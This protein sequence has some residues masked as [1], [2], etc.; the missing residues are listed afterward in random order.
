MT[1]LL[2]ILLLYRKGILV[3]PWIGMILF[4]CQ[5]SSDLEASLATPL[6]EN[7]DYN[8][9]IKPILSDRCYAC[10]GPD[11]KT[12]EADLRLDT[13]EGALKMKLESGKP[14]IV[15][16]STSRSE[17][18]H[19][20]TSDDPQVLMPPPESHLTLSDYE[21]ALLG[22]WI[23]Q[24]AEWK[25]HWSFIPPERPDIPRISQKDFPIHEI[26]HFIL[27]QLERKGLTPS[28][29]ADKTRLIRRLSL[30]LRGLPP[31]LEEIDV[32]LQDEDPDAYEKLVDTYLSDPA[33]GERMALDWMDVA[34]YADSHGMHADGWRNMWPWRDWVIQAFNDNMPYDQFIMYQMAGDM[35]PDATKDQILATAFHRNHQMTAEGGVIDEE[36]RL[37]YVFDRTNTTATAFLGLTMECARC[38]DHKFDPL[39]QKDFYALAAF[40]N[41]VKEVGMTGDDGNYGPVMLMSSDT[42]EAKLNALDQ[43]INKLYQQKKLSQSEVQAQKAFLTTLDRSSV[44]PQRFLLAHYPLDKLTKQRNASGNPQ[45]LLD[46]NDQST[47]T[48][49]PELVKGKIGKALRFDHDYDVLY[50]HDIA[51]FEITE[52]FSIGTWIKPE[53]KGEHQTIIGNSGNKNNFWRGWEMTLDTSN[54]LWVRLIHS[55]PHNYIHIASEQTIPLD[56][57]TQVMFTYDGTA[58]ASGVKL[59]INGRNVPVQIHFDQLYKSMRTIDSRH[60]PEDRALRVA[61]SY[62]AFTG[63]NGIYLG[64]IDD[65]RIYDE[66]LTELEVAAIHP[67]SEVYERLLAE[68]PESTDQHLAARKDRKKTNLDQKIQLLLEKRLTMIDTVSEVMV[69]GEMKQPRPMYVLERG[70]YAAPQEQVAPATPKAV[71]PF[72]DD[73]PPN[74]V[75]LAQWLI[76]PKNP[77]TARVTV[78]RYWQMIFGQGLVKTPQ[79]FGSQGNLPTHPLLLDHL[80]TWLVAS[81]W[82]IKALMKYMVMSATYQQE[83]TLRPQLI[84]IDPNNELLA[85]GPSFRLPA[86]HIRDHALTVSGL[87]IDQIGGPSVKPYQPP[88]LWIDKGNF[89]P[90]LL[91]YVQDSGANLYRRGLYT[92]VRRT[93]PPP[94]MIA[95]DA[96]DR[97]YCSVQRQTTNTPMQALV[98]L[99]DPQFVEAS[100]VMAERIIREGGNDLNDQLQYGFRLA[101]GRVPHT[102]ELNILNGL[103][104]EEWKR[105]VLAPDSAQALLQT[106]AYP[107]D[108]TLNLTQLAA[109]TNVASMLL[110]HDEAYMKR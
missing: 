63:D 25:S 66:A 44:Q 96:T 45:L 104:Q 22:K 26:D 47:A 82:D 15:A 56:T 31:T 33:F 12:R 110:N 58:K 20:I 53:K 67:D 51:N 69:M 10:H 97:S 72:P 105:F 74:R 94:S 49:E 86:E 100:R 52:S 21:V 13:P 93:S 101:T 83:S 42:L 109:M 32:F 19:R 35:L 50:L 2:H 24:G 11:D 59:Y 57:W 34:R 88:G 38:H 55:L 9:H 79:D 77:L 107:R 7:I 23:E 5:S 81:G 78:N 98:L 64:S 16:G 76:S 73:F 89:S 84:S 103:Y 36:F 65:I 43:Q 1:T 39:S 62:R 108:T 80:A 28:P 70:S 48:G 90:K 37:E 27:A 68:K 102:E 41:N 71:L 61:K 106:G 8:Y 95:F 29:K 91:Y 14:A 85:R 54:H 92:F 75:G 4:S 18:W 87:L 30:D 3:L 60:N 40:F 6:P 46:L 99:N 17:F